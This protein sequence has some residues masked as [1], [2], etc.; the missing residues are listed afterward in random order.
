M[1]DIVNEFLTNYLA[2]ASAVMASIVAYTAVY[3]NS[4]PQLI[5]YY[6]PSQRQQTMIDLI[7][8]NIGKG[9]ATDIQFSKPIPIGWNGIETPFGKGSYIPKSGIPSLAPG[10]RLVF[11]GGQFG[12]LSKELGTKGIELNITYKFNPPLRCQ[13]KLL[14]PAYYL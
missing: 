8:E 12:G 2:P 13:K 4:E 9:N 1:L 6:H 11:S 5:A 7:I 10:Q 3:K 14:I